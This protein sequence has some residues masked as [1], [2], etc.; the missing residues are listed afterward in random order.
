MNMTLSKR[1]DYVM[2]SAIALA[3][4][5]ESGAPRKI[6]QVV[7]DTE[8]PRTFASQILADL[9]RAGIAVS[10]AGRDGGYRL[11]RAPA[12]ISVLEV[13]EAAE[14]PLRAERCALGEGPCRWES[15]CPLHE[16]WSVATAKLAELLAATSLAEV[17]SRDEAIEAGLYSVPADAHRSHPLA[18][19]VSDSVQVELAADVLEAA[20]TAGGHNWSAI[21]GAAVHEVGDHPRPQGRPQTLVA[22]C[23]LDSVRQDGAED[24]SSRYVMA[25]RI[26]GS[27]GTSHFEGELTDA[28]VDADRSELRLA[29]TWHQEIDGGS[30]LTSEELAELARRVVRD[31]LRRVAWAVEGTPR[32]ADH[33]S[34]AGPASVTKLVAT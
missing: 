15:V 23:S 8:V 7:A 20:L 30:S 31:V 5:Y 10:R 6:R 28:V 26:S 27:A 12:D 9:V 16:T 19:Q 32:S 33:V 11:S 21:V 25:W 13:V 29:G 17:A 22:E 18:V 3:R 1:G 34:P 2:R 4:A 24:V 14:G